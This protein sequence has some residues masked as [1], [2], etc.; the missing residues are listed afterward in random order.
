MLTLISSVQ[1]QIKNQGLHD[2]SLSKW[3]E[4]LAQNPPRSTTIPGINPRV[5][6]IQSR[7]EEYLADEVQKITAELTLLGTSDVIE[8]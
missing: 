4:S 2:R 7:I 8:S 3:L 1:T 5:Q 6:K